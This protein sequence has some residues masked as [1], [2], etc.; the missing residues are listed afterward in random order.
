MLKH[1]R[2]IVSTRVLTNKI[3]NL[4]KHQTLK[5]NTF[6][7]FF[8]KVNSAASAVVVK[9]KLLTSFLKLFWNFKALIDVSE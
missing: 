8:K 4:M 2:E 9:I 6:R 7:S 3:R 1:F 5:N